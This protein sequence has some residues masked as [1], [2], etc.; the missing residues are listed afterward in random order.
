MLP[1]PIR[2]RLLAV[3][4]YPLTTS[5]YGAADIILTAIKDMNKFKA[6]GCDGIKSKTLFLWHCEI[7]LRFVI[8]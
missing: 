8:I 3:D 6:M 1:A 5:L 4:Q 7:T 2:D